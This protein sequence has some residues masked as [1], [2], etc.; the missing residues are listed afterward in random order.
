MRGFDI[1]LFSDWIPPT[2]RKKESW[3]I[4]FLS[5]NTTYMYS[6]RFFVSVI[7]LGVLLPGFS[8]NVSTGYPDIDQQL[9][10]AGLSVL[11]SATLRLESQ[12]EVTV[13]VT[14]YGGNLYY[15]AT[16]YDRANDQPLQVALHDGQGSTYLRGTQGVEMDL[17][18]VHGAFSMKLTLENPHDL[19]I[20]ELLLV[21][22]YKSFTNGTSDHTANAPAKAYYTLEGLS[23]IEQ[24]RQQTVDQIKAYLTTELNK[25]GYSVSD[26]KVFLHDAKKS[27]WPYTFCRE[28]DYIIFG[29][30]GDGQPTVYELIDPATVKEN[31]FGGKP[32]ERDEKIIQVSNQ[33]S[34]GVSFRDKN[35]NYWRWSIRPD[36]SQQQFGGFSVYVVGYKSADNTTNQVSNNKPEKY[37]IR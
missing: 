34:V 13:P 32:V 5:I 17:R 7:I 23:L 35:P 28:N 26:A 15:V 20:S 10:G 24:A 11:S 3:V 31:P 22:S 6:V 30:G 18:S 21:Q 1:Q 37:Y 25:Q 27:I 16:A 33:G 9:H 19:P 12:G 2:S 4:I 36:A 14:L 29:M 8:Q